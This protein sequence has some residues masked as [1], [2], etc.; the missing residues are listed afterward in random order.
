MN[1]RSDAPGE[2]LTNEEDDEESLGDEDV[3][4]YRQQR[5]GL[6]IWPKIDRLSALR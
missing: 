6:T 1:A 3:K 2:K 5:L 4:R